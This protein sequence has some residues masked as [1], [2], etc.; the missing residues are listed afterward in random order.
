MRRRLNHD[1]KVYGIV[2]VLLLNS[3]GY[4]P[5]IHSL[6][7]ITLRQLGLVKLAAQMLLLI[8]RY[9]A[10]SLCFLNI[11]DEWLEGTKGE[12]QAYGMAGK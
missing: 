2:I 12:L 5:T 3:V 7:L 6:P 8:V 1:Y 9:R 4:S 10:A 11:L